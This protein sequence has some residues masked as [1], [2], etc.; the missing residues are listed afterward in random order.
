MRKGKE[1]KGMRILNY[2]I[3]ITDRNNWI[4]YFGEKS[5]FYCC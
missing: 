2:F 3:S 4:G 5:K 1:G